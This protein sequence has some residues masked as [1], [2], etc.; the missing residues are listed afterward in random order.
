MKKRIVVFASGNKG[1][2][3]GGGSGAEKL[4]EASRT[5]I[6]DAEIV[7]FVSN[8]SEGGVQERALRLGIPFIHFPGTTFSADEYRP[9]FEETRP[10]VTSLSGWLKPMRGH[11]PRTTINIHPGYLPGYGGR[12]M[13]GHHVHERVLHDFKKGLIKASAVTMHFVTDGYD[14]GPI[15][16]QRSVPIEPDDT[17]D[18]LGKR[19]NA[20]EHAW[21]AKITNWVVAGRISWDGKDPASLDVPDGYQI[22]M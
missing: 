4:V 9:I 17:P 3:A 11:D 6:L 16:F 8:N 10:D 22:F 21:Q 13:Y 5:G 15:F 1:K 12:G 2:G 20:L 18:T 19:V 7:A 14:E